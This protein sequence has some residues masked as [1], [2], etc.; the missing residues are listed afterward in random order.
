MDIMVTG[1]ANDQG[2]ASSFEHHVRPARP[3]FPH[4]FEI[5]EFASLMHDTVVISAFTQL[6]SARDESPYHLLLLITVQSRNFLNED[7]FFAVPQRDSTELRD[8]R[9]LS[10]R[11]FQ[12]SLEAFSWAV[13]GLGDGPVPLDH[14]RDGAV[15]FG[16]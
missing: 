9:F 6:A 2:F 11:T 3:F 4:L 13:W 15:I 1:L 12:T 8:Q 14:L 5:C 7:R 16:R 10:I